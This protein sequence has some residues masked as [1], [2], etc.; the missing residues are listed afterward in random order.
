M[1]KL[2]TRKHNK[3]QS[4]QKTRKLSPTSVSQ[5]LDDDFED[6]DIMEE[7]Y[8]E[9]IEIDD[10]SVD[11]NVN[12]SGNKKISLLSLQQYKFTRSS[13][14]NIILY[15]RSGGTK[16][17]ID[18]DQRQRDRFIEKYSNDFSIDRDKLIYKPLNLE[19]VP[20]EEKTIRLEEIFS[21][22]ESIGKGI[23]NF[24][25][26]VLRK[27]LG[28][29]RQCIIDFLRS[30]PQY[31]LFQKKPTIVSKSIYPTYPLQYVAID[32]VDMTE[33]ETKKGFAGDM[34]N[35]GH[36]YIFVAVDLYTNYSWFYSMSK[37]TKENTL[38]AFKKMMTHNLEYS[39][40]GDDNKDRRKQMV[41][42]EDFDFPTNILTDNGTEFKNTLVETFLK[43]HNMKQ[44]FRDSY[45]PEPHVEAVNN[46]LRNLIR[47]QYIRTKD[48][49][50]YRYLDDFMR[51]KNSNRDENT[52]EPAN[53]LLSTYLKQIADENVRNVQNKKSRK[54]LKKVTDDILRSS[55]KVRHNKSRK[56]YNAVID[57][58]ER[59]ELKI[60]DKVRVRVANYQT[61]V[62]K[63]LKEGKGKKIVFRY[64]A[65]VF[66][67]AEIKKPKNTGGFGLP[68][69]TLRDSNGMWVV[70]PKGKTKELV[71]SN[72]LDKVDKRLF[73]RSDL[74]EVSQRTESEGYITHS[75]LNKL[76]NVPDEYLN[77]T[78]ENTPQSTTE[79]NESDPIEQPSRDILETLP[80]EK[81][82]VK[83]WRKALVGKE[84]NDI[85]ENDDEMKRWHIT[86]VTFKQGS[87]GFKS[88][89]IVYYRQKNT[90]ETEN[91]FLPWLF[92]EEKY[93]EVRKEEW[94]KEKYKSLADPR[95]RDETRSD[96]F[97]EGD[98]VKAWWW[99]NKEHNK[100]Y[101]AKIEQVNKNGTYDII[102]QKDRKKE[103]GVRPKYMSY[104]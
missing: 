7:D 12:R 21:S 46:V 27:Y 32:L 58:V 9:M 93:S 29:P 35:S 52:G 69:Y 45:S 68:Y 102:Y 67:V 104:L 90:R 42:D 95:Y 3:K 6:E 56:T 23:N 34:R 33:D 87:D 100:A 73:K 15:I 18:L 75:E 36:R 44:I 79:S 78:P 55:R 57:K 16:L 80:V 91:T 74:M 60:G 41:R 51:A 40:P 25:H 76:N 85:D 103:R 37:K 19:V 8:D 28:I 49:I 62:R 72:N 10:E 2:L 66:T 101:K 39:F 5:D 50:Y 97:L 38:I 98:V 70:N 59:Q 82:R 31:Q 77:R 43:K 17:P 48:K 30:K 94:F 20:E 81:W 47:A 22:P 89:Y 65:K 96:T 71:V 26:M 1:V 92:S 83:E 84:F 13:I 14:E 88:T 53:K 63:L 99:K 61:S 64:S 86:D 4:Q 54:R 24:H 11:D